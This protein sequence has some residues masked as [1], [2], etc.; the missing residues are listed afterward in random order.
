MDY[1]YEEEIVSTVNN[2]CSEKDSFKLEKL[3]LLLK[4]LQEK[5]GDMNELWEIEYSISEKKNID[6]LLSNLS[7]EE[8]KKLVSLVT[9]MEVGYQIQLSSMLNEESRH[10]YE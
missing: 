4:K 9:E 2:V 3:E 6:N 7:L 5:I 1:V 10:F 8:L